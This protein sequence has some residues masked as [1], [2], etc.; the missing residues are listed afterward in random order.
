MDLNAKPIVYISYSRQ[1]IELV[2]ILKNSLIEFE[3]NV[4]YD[5]ILLNAGVNW[6][7]KLIN[8][9]K[10]ANCVIILITKNSIS[11]KYVMNELG[12]ARGLF[13]NDE[14]KILI[15][16]IYGDIP[17]PEFIQDVQ[18][19]YWNK[20]DVSYKKLID[21]IV[22]SLSHNKKN[23]KNSI[24]YPI[25]KIESENEKKINGEKINED[26]KMD[27]EFVRIYKPFYLTEGDLKNT[28]DQLDF[29]NDINSFASVISLKKVCPPLAIGLFG[30]WGS[31]KSF[32]ME[33]LSDRIDQIA[34][35]GQQ[36]E[37]IEHVVQVK[38]NSWHY[39]DSNLWASLI[40][41]IFES[42]HDFAT[43]RNYG[44]DAIH[45]IYKDLI[46]TSFQL[47]ETQ[48]KLDE[49]I[50]QEIILEQRKSDLE[51][52][53]EQK[54]ASLSI[55]N[56]RDFMKIIASDPFIKHDF[57]NIKSEFE[58]EKLIDNIEQIDSK[59]VEFNNSK[60]LIVETFNLLK[61]NS[62]G[63]WVMVW[64]L[65]ALSILLIYLTQGPFKI[66]VEKIISHGI[67][68]SGIILS[69]LTIISAQLSP[70]YKK[71][72]LFYKRLISLKE[73]I[74]KEKEKVR[75]NEHT[76]IDRLNEDISNLNSK[77]DN[78]VVNQVQIN[79]KKTKLENEINDI[80]SGKQLASFLTNKS[81]DQIYNNNLGIISWI[82]KEF[83]KLNELFIKQ[84]VVNTEENNISSEL[85]IDRIVLYIDDLDRCNEDVV[86]KVLEAIHLLLAF[87]LFVVVVGVDP[88]WLN[89]AL[90]VKYKN[91]FS[92]NGKKYNFVGNE[93][94]QDDSE[95]ENSLF[96]GV[97][98]SYDYLEKIF[99]IPFALKRINKTGREKLIEYLTRNEMFG[100]KKTPIKQDRA[101]LLNQEVQ[102]LKNKEKQKVKTMQFPKVVVEQ[103]VVFT[104]F[105]LSY[106]QKIS[107]LFGNT[108][109]T[110]NRYINIYRII[111]AH[112]NLKVSI[113][114]SKNDYMPL[115]FVLGVVVGYSSY[116]EE[117]ISK[118][119]EANNMNFG[120]FILN[121]NMD[122]PFMSL[123]S[124][125]SE[126]L[127]DIPIENF[128]PN[129]ELISRFS[130]R[131][132]LI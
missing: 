107:L 113:E 74:D 54:K 109:R 53:I 24:K 75:I 117:F 108:P 93:R 16:I 57:E 86:V 11:S 101:A 33:K 116:A 13:T 121:I 44:A 5:E 69:Y 88:R 7:E 37:Y 4:I 31:G 26:N 84:E 120:I 125:I 67:V 6:R 77:I 105:E 48:K 76:E 42:L 131:T 56:A 63:K 1:D 62:M 81:E 118:I 41:H 71:V 83:E 40:T 65:L 87:P 10:N 91:L 114:F 132:L 36:D 85:K 110:I 12:F 55:W 17:I 39:S 100:G 66:F 102:K 119:S 28:D 21:N 126:D 73:T 82:R 127:S 99:Q 59:I 64:L 20:S 47:K 98:T 61:K 38:F 25:L 90:S 94:E 115:M 18:V 106:M 2:S 79:E 15:P 95:E 103:L 27:L 78:I 22:S 29:E 89:N 72:K 97:A 9:I 3:I 30:N 124:L 122:E 8:G 111:K 58:E 130:F 14:N 60:G 96:S 43:K 68:I 32:F 112:G 34:N 19:L 80:G 35:S 46:I 128:K 104:D 51:G 50:A 123:I 92:L 23:K 49:K 52:I 129:L 70:Y 45:A